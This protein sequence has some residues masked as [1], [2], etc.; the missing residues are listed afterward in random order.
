MLTTRPEELTTRS[1]MS[2]FMHHRKC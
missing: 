2:S 1:T